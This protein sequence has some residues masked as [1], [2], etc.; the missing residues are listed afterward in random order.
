MVNNS[1]KVQINHLKLIFLKIKKILIRFKIEILMLKKNHQ[2]IQEKVSCNNLIN[3]FWIDVNGKVA[4]VNL[5][6]NI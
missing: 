6:S 3:I 2:Y 1:C 5:L 4:I